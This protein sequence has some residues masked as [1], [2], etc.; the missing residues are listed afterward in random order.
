MATPLSHRPELADSSQGSHMCSGSSARRLGLR[1]LVLS[2]LC[3]LL[4]LGFRPDQLHPGNIYEKGMCVQPERETR[5][6]MHHF[7]R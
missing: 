2:T 7:L 6:C 3:H 1:H 4:S 5:E